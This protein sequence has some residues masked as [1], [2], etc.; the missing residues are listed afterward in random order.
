[1]MMNNK[2]LHLVLELEK[3]IS[4]TYAVFLNEASND[5]LYENVFSMMEDTYDMTREIYNMMYRYKLVDINEI[6]NDIL[7]DRVNNLNMLIQSLS[8][9][10]D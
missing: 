8:T 3:S 6:D 4:N 1:M 9:K 2:Y 5:Y 10:K 7:G